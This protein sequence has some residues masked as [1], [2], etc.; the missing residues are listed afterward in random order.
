[1]FFTTY[2]SLSFI[3]VTAFP[4]D[5]SLVPSLPIAYGL[6]HLGSMH[7]TTC[8]TNTYWVCYCGQRKLDREKFSMLIKN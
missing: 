1:M 7:L 4:S 5:L 8:K 3:N 2:F 6:S